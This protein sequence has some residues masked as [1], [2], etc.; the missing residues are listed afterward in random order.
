MNKGADMLLSSSYKHALYTPHPLFFLSTFHLCLSEFRGVSKMYQQLWLVSLLCWQRLEKTIGEIAG[1]LWSV[2]SKSFCVCECLIWWEKKSGW[3]YVLH[4]HCW[5]T[6]TNIFLSWNIP[7]FQS[8]YA[9]NHVSSLKVW[10]SS[11]PGRP[12]IFDFT[13][14]GSQKAVIIQKINM[15]MCVP[16]TN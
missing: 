6:S 16:S 4:A 12:D 15:L 5:Y 1:I 2:Q 10:I 9:T 13:I 14:L 7:L 3:Q 11:L 8:F